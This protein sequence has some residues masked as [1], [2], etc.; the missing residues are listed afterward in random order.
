MPS[1]A[2]SK[3]SDD[4][5]G[6]VLLEGECPAPLCRD[7]PRHIAAAGLAVVG[8]PATVAP[9]RSVGVRANNMAM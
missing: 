4:S 7:S 8:V 1:T 9:S 2:S 3:Q 6:S 5:Y